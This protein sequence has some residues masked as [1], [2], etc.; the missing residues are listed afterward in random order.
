MRSANFQMDLERR[1][2]IGYGKSPPNPCWPGNAKLAIN[3]VVNYEEGG[4][5]C[6]LSNDLASEVFLNETPGGIPRPHRDINMET[7]YE[8]GSRCGVW[9]ILRLFNKFKMKFTC[10]AVGKAVEANPDAI[11][12]MEKEGH[13]IGSN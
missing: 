2:F 3:F 11:R 12:A 7:Q 13:E 8:Y 10:Y 1:D 4:E 5:N 6:V 9:R